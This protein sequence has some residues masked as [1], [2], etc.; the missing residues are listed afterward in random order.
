MV[1]LAC[2]AKLTL[3]R[4]RHSSRIFV[5][6]LVLAA[7]LPV[8]SGAQTGFGPDTVIV[9][10]GALKLRALLWRPR[11]PPPFPAVLFNHGSGHGVRAPSGDYDEHTMEWQAGILGPVFARH[12]YLFLYV[13]RRGTGLSGD[14]GTNSSDRWDRELATNGREARNRLQLQLLETGE[15][16][17]ALAGLAFLRQSPEVDPHR[18]AVAGHSFGGSLTMLVAERDS[19]LRAAIVFSG[20][21][22]SWPQSPSLRDRLLKAADHTVIPV[23]FISAENDY[24][25]TPGKALAAEMTRLGKSNRLKIY[26]PV[27]HT[28]AAGHGFVHLRVASWEPDVF[29]FLDPLMR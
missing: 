23:F 18:V 15:L 25:V 11:G 1:K 13:L 4:V 2:A 27:G 28:A 10:S 20:S 7:G 8:Q 14:Q 19:A 22:R 21:A 12:G 24:S 29:A 5:F 9:P 26:P 3:V 6:A 17:D 16:D